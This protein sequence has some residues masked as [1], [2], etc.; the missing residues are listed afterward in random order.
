M[1]TAQEILVELENVG[2]DSIKKTLMRHGIKEP[3]YGVKIEE[4]KKILKRVKENHDLSIALYDSGIYDAR[5]L[6]GLVAEPAKM[7]KAELQKWV[8]QA[9]APIL[10]ETTVSAVAAEGKYGLELALEWVDSE[11]EGIACAGWSTLS[12]LV[13]IKDDKDLDFPLL[14]K[15]MARV[16]KQINSAPNRVRYCMNVFIISVGCYVK[17]LNEHAKETARKIGKVMVDVG[18]TACMVPSAIDYIA[19]VEA[20]NSVGKKKKSARC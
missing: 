4:L 6:A 14:K 19:K 17:E 1:M 2:V 5:Y 12:Q 18:D 20:R 8:K 3:L 9:N 13:A 16:V 15:L 11:E 10:F 7:T